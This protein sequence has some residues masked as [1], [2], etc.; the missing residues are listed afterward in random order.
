MDL[1]IPRKGVV[2]RLLLVRKPL[3]D[4]IGRKFLRSDS[5]GI[6]REF[7]AILKQEFRRNHS[8]TPAPQGL[9]LSQLG[10]SVIESR[11]FNR[12]EQGK[13]RRKQGKLPA[14]SESAVTVHGGSALRLC[15]G[16]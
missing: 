15:P 10:G 4:G 2:C 8:R 9:A 11:E 16:E 14:R 5:A 3:G 13:Q 12:S 6:C 7:G 1:S